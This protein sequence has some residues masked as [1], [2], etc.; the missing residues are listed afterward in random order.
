MKFNNF[1]QKNIRLISSKKFY[2]RKNKEFDFWTWTLQT[3][4]KN[5]ILKSD[6]N[7]PI[8]NLNDPQMWN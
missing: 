5:L 3:D 6:L 2:S 8:N 4:E 1:S 7:F